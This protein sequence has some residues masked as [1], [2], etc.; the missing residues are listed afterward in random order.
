[1]MPK[2]MPPVAQPIIVTLVAHAPQFFT[3]TSAAPAP[4]ISRMAGSR[5]NVKIRWSMQS[6][7]QPSDAIMTTN[8]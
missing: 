7:N 4:R 2:I 6:N 8:Q 1:M 3:I 5:D